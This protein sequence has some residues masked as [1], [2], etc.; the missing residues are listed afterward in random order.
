[1][2][3]PV[4][5]RLQKVTNPDGSWISYTY[6]NNG[7]KLTETTA[8]GTTTYTYDALNRVETVKDSAER[9]TSYLYA[10]NGRVDT[11][12]LPNGVTTKHTY[13][14]L[15]RL[16]DLVTKNS[17]GE[18][19]ASYGYQ[20]DANGN[21]TKVTEN[22]G[23]TVDYGYDDLNRLTLE[24]VGSPGAQRSATATY[25]LD[26]TG[27][28]LTKTDESGTVT[29]VYDANDRLTSET[30]P[31][32]TVAYSYD[33]NG[34]TLNDGTSTFGYD[35][36]NRLVSV[37]KGSDSAS[38]TYDVSGNRTSKTVNG[39]KTKYLVCT[40]CA[41]GQVIE[42]LNS[43]GVL[44][45]RY[46]IGNRLISQQRGESNYFYLQDG[47]GST[48]G[49]VNQN[50]IISDYYSYNA[51]GTLTD[52][53]GTTANDFLFTG[54]QYD[55]ETS[56]Y[57]LRARYYNP[58]NGRFSRMDSWGGDNNKP[59]TLNKYIYGNANPVIY[60]DPNGKFGLIEAFAAVSAMSILA[61]SAMGYYSVPGIPRY[62]NNEERAFLI[63]YMG[64]PFDASQIKVTNSILK[65]RPSSPFD[66]IIML[67]K[68]CFIGGQVSACISFG[69]TTCKGDFIHES[70]H[71]WQRQM[72]K[73]VTL[74]GIGWQLLDSFGLYDPYG[75]D[76]KE[77]NPYKMLKIFF[78]AN[79]EAQAKIFET[80]ALFVTFEEYREV[81]KY[82]KSPLNYIYPLDFSMEDE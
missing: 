52:H 46:T 16:T 6:D 74:P 66:G 17:A 24:T 25:T 62:L 60:I 13:D 49:I 29:Y 31:G 14:D 39:E 27:N 73:Y 2:Y 21:R 32:G 47:L 22:T 23:R 1:V 43:S 41:Y 7:N 38:Y 4:T 82:V 19:L 11:I 58:T 48:R 54:E 18:I 76:K 67:Q 81:R 10:P 34:N 15:G 44:N 59:I 63:N 28:R 61:T 77:A 51:Y 30:G 70:F 57:Y 36:K 75:Y 33:S 45:V 9:I 65:S 35:K 78:K 53:S 72:G 50:G 79:I 3:F 5:G 40:I 8:N 20:L 56:N 71:V 68:K 26:P 80:A 12:T 55:S 37:M 69:D 42:E 64:P